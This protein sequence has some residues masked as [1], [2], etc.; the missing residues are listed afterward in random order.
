MW[1]LCL[2]I[3]PLLRIMTHVGNPIMNLLF[4]DGQ[5]PIGLVIVGMGLMTP[6][7][8]NFEQLNCSESKGPST[9]HFTIQRG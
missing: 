9:P 2:L 8:S 7:A 6:G 4:G 1:D 5:A 3:K